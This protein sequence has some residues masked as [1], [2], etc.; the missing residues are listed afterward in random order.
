MDDARQ[1]VAEG[2]PGPSLCDSHHVLQRRTLDCFHLICFLPN[3]V[4]Q[5][6]ILWCLFVSFGFCVVDRLFVC[7]FT[8]PVRARGQPCDWIGVGS[9]YPACLERNTDELS[10]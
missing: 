9:A 2:L 1:E 3:H 5:F 6:I 4:F 8:C 10:S 7:L